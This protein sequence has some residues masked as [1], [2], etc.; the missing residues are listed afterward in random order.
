MDPLADM[1]IR[2]KNAQAVKKQTVA[3]PYSRLKMD[4]LKL[5][6]REGYVEGVVRKGR[7]ARKTIE[8]ALGYDK[9]GEPH[10]RGVRRVSKP[11]RRVYCAAKDIVRSQNATGL[12][13][14]TTPK[15]IL[16][17][18]EAKKEHVGGEMICEIW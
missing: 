12:N 4:V 11:S 6:Q 10:I 2:L 9:E 15:G 13:V 18:A 5:L 7:K 17:D 1:F 3:I 14:L 8:V 16:T